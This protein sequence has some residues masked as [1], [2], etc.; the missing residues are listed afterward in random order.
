MASTLLSLRDVSLIIDQ[1]PLFSGINLHVREGERHCL[2]G[3]NGAGKTTLLKLLVGELEPD[4]GERFVQPGTRIGMLAQEPRWKGDP[5]VMEFASELLEPGE[6]YRAEWLLAEAGLQPDQKMNTLSGGGVKR[7]ALA[8]VLAYQ[9]EVLLLDEPTNHLDVLAIEWLEQQI[10]NYRGA[11]IIISHDRSFLVNIT[12]RML[13]LDRGG[14]RTQDEGFARFEQWMEEIV[15]AEA[16]EMQRLGKKLEDEQHWL[17]YGVTARRRRN[18]R[19]MAELQ[20]LRERIKTERAHVAKA[21]TSVQGMNVKVDKSAERAVEMEHIAK[22]YALP[23]GDQK[24]IAKDFT[25]SVIRGDRIGLVGP[26]GVGK[27]SVIKMMLGHETPDAGTV[28]LGARLDISWFDQRRESLDP[29]KTLWDTLCPTGGD[30]VQVGG[31][32]RHVVSYLKD[33]L[34][35]QEQAK[36]PVGSLSG[37]EAN[38]LLLAKI[39]ASPGN[40]LILDEPTNDLDMDTLEVLLDV[41]GE[42]NGTLIVVSHDRDFLDRLVNRCWLFEG[43]GEITEIIGGYKECKA[44]LDAKPKKVVAA[45]VV[46]E[47]PVGERK[48]NAKPGKLSFKLERELALLP[49]KI[50]ALKREIA[51]LEDELA[52]T[53]LYKRNAVR[54]DEASRRLPAAQKELADAEERWLELEMMKEELAS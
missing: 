6:E 29:T 8:R 54:F 24:V 37:G 22:R 44:W 21:T 39:L 5:T 43:E 47:K 46:A 2:I 36:S 4:E 3:R 50:E 7:A 41:L 51:A 18:Q 1:A 38:R 17:K 19:R 35:A 11:V 9:P 27:T 20:S 12:N 42:Y 32:M 14:M 52:D 10:K 23:D 30:F 31:E 25:V 45:K 34:F 48:S 15:L 40:L 13:W 28:T 33:F 16:K 26:N 49:E 53:S